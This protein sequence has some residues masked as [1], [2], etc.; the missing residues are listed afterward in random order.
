[1]PRPATAALTAL[2]VGGVTSAFVAPVALLHATTAARGAA[3]AQSLEAVAG[4]GV[5]LELGASGTGRAYYPVTSARLSGLTLSFGTSSLVL[6]GEVLAAAA[7]GGRISRVSLAFRTP[8]PD[9]RPTTELVDTF[10]AATV[11]SVTEH[12]SGSPA[13]RVALLLP[14]ASEVASTPGTL[15]HAGPFAA[16]SGGAA[17][18]AAAAPAAKAYVSLGA[19]A[20]SYAVTA[21]AVSQ[22]APGAPLDLS[23][24]TSALPLLHGIFQA[25]GA[26]AIPALAVTVRA[27]DGGRLLWHTFSGLKVSSFAETLSG[28][29]SG[30]ATLVVRPR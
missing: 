8:G 5:Y 27:P 22:A 11:T 25:G 6:L 23:L 20:P 1:V 30:T 26:A 3:S 18:G 15:Q 19:G 16:P 9:G 10:A 2:C 7:D 17:G 29:V 4:T 13:G 14:A 24:T 21:F 28:A 12:L